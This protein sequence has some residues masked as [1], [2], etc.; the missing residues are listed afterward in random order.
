MYKKKYRLK[1]ISS[2]RN[3][4]M[5]AEI[6]GK[7][8]YIAYLNVGE[9]GWFLCDT[10]EVIDPVHRIRTSE[11]KD[12][13]YTDNKVFVSTNNTKYEFEEIK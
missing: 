11:V 2:R 7:V 13:Q 1:S 9:R 4:P 5:Y 6:L 3:N 10:E 12:V 8:C